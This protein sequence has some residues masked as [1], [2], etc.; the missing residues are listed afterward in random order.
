VVEIPVPLRC[1]RADLAISLKCRPLP[2]PPQRAN[3]WR[4][5]EAVPRHPHPGNP[6]LRCNSNDC[7]DGR[8]KQMNVL[9]SV[10]MVNSDSI[11]QQNLDLGRYLPGDLSLKR[12]IS[13]P[14][15]KVLR[16]GFTQEERIRA[17]Q[18]AKVG[19]TGLPSERLRWTPTETLLRPNERMRCNASSRPVH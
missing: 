11:I 16:R 6:V 7:G 15:Q 4:A 9:V 17:R 14:H 5:E 18:E 3:R 8:G 1:C 10:Q 2:S 12:L 19:D 13:G